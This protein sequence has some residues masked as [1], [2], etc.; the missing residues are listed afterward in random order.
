M[1]CGN[2]D[3]KFSHWHYKVVSVRW[4][5][6]NY[7]FSLLPSIHLLFG[8]STFYFITP[9]SLELTYILVRSVLFLLSN[10]VHYQQIYGKLI[11]LSVSWLWKL[12]FLHV[13][14]MWNLA[15]AKIGEGILLDHG[16][17]VVIGETAVIGNRVSLMQV[18]IFF[19]QIM[20][21]EVLQIVCKLKSR[22]AIIFSR[23]LGFNPILL[24]D[25]E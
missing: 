10:K 2:K 16:T 3:V 23:N 17:G 12:W 25:R 11:S 14:S 22:A 19:A 1:H 9:R 15:A 6:F 18:I 13:L 20:L 4:N 21:V 7:H 5:W 8:L 24:I